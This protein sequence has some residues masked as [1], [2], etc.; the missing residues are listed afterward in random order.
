[1]ALPY[2]QRPGARTLVRST[3]PRTDLLFPTTLLHT[4]RYLAFAITIASSTPRCLRRS[5]PSSARHSHATFCGL[6]SALQSLLRGPA[7]ASLHG[8]WAGRHKKSSGPCGTG[9]DL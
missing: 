9:A 5:R 6:K 7:L 3:P 4:K 8:P 1:M 2:A